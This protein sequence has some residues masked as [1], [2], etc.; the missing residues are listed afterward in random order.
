M[1]R[2]CICLLHE[3]MR[4][5]RESAWKAVCKKYV[6]QRKQGCGDWDDKDSFAT[7]TFDYG[8]QK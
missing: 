7:N 5:K 8:N 6:V 4:N 2:D 3:E 1:F